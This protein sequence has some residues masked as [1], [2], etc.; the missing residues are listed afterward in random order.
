MF[1]EPSQV[2]TR[3]VSIGD[4]SDSCLYLHPPARIEFE[5]PTNTA[6]KLTTAIAIQPEAW[7]QSGAGGCEFSVSINDQNI[8][9]KRINPTKLSADRCWHE[10]AIDLPAGAG[11]CNKISFAT[12]A[13]GNPAYYRW[14]VWRRPVFSWK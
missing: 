8:F 7:E 2:E 13:L 14:A 12:R 5:L 10:I 9:S 3:F 6:G 11:K 4:V 1:G